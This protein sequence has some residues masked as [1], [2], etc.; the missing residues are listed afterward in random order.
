MLRKWEINYD[1]ENSLDLRMPPDVSMMDL[2]GAANGGA[3]LA[4]FASAHVSTACKAV[5]A[6]TESVH[7]RASDILARLSDALRGAA[8]ALHSLGKIWNQYSAQRALDA[9]ALLG[10]PPEAWI[11]N[12]RREWA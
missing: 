6:S 3:A 4:L 5:S 8:V 11:D 12:W 7:R 1:L 2:L 10:V 9:G